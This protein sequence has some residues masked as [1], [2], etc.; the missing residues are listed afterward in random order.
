[1]LVLAACAAAAV[2]IATAPHGPRVTSDS[3][4]YLSTAD[5]VRAGH[6]LLFYEGLPLTQYPPGFPVLLA[7]AGEVAGSSVLGA[8]LLNALCLALVV[9]LGW[10]LLRNHVRSRALRLAGAIALA[11]APTLFFVSSTAWSEAPFLVLTLASVLALE[12]A[13]ARPRLRRWVVAAALLAGGSFWLRYSGLWL[14]VT[15]PVVLLVANRRMLTARERL[16]RAGL[17]VLVACVTG[18]FVVERNLRLTDGYPFSNRGPAN[19]SVGQALSDT[20]AELA[21][22]FVP[23]GASAALRVLL[24]AALIATL[25]A[26]MASRRTTAARPRATAHRATLWPLALLVAGYVAVLLVST[27]AFLDPIGARLLSPAFVPVIVL[28]LAGVDHLVARTGSYRPLIVTA[29]ALTLVWLGAQTQATE[30]QF[31]DLRHDGSF[32]TGPR[33]RSSALMALVDGGGIRP[34]YSNRTDVLYFRTSLFANCWP[35]RTQTVCTA[36]GPNLDLLGQSGSGYLAW[37]D[38]PGGSVPYLP[39]AV[40][41]RVRLTLV[42]RVADGALYRVRRL[43]P[44]SP[45]K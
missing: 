21:R 30:A 36:S 13:L 20:A 1:V 43:A 2:L 32:Y 16:T 35:T 12:A 26:W 31:S 17:F 41:G 23:D 5:S 27:S 33:W 8:R 39:R 6:G 9:L 34:A 19:T 25:G 37:F 3:V 45:E 11:L 42:R 44:S 28:A 38:E 22:W 24:V 4:L 15:V 18:A 40:A 14:I 7:G 10:L 29:A